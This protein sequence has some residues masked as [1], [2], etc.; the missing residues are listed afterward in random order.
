MGFRFLLPLALAALLS[1]C[2]DGQGASETRSGPPCPGNLQ[3]VA[4]QVFQPELHRRRLSR[5]RR[6]RRRPRPRNRRARGAALRP[7]GCSLRWGGAR[8]PWRC[9][10]LAPHCQASRYE[11]LRCADATNRRSARPR[12]CRLH[13]VVDRRSRPRDHLREL[14]RRP[15]R[16]PHEQPRAL[17]RVRQRLPRHSSVRRRRLHLPRRRI[18][19]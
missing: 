19:L 3:D 8:R 18:R 7:R 15:L 4:V 11:R 5:L 6:P 16:R 17:W 9:R 12:H 1:A 14:R 10:E 13:G 2:S